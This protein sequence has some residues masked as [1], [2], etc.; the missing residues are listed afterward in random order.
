VGDNDVVAKQWSLI[1]T[2][3]A[4]HL[5]PSRRVP[6]ATTT[7][8]MKQMSRCRKR[9]WT[10]MGEG[11]NDPM[12]TWHQLGGNRCRHQKA[13]QCILT[14]GTHQKGRVSLRAQVTKQQVIFHCASACPK[15][16]HVML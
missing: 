8:T 11:D 9:V 2:A 7:M 3:S 16:N 6:M 4:N 12:T 10:P 15:I 1:V 5:P 13:A 14:Y